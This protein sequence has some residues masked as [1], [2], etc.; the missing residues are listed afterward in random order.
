M[1]GFTWLWLSTLSF[2]IGWITGN[3]SQ[4]WLVL[5]LSDS[6]FWVGLGVGVRGFSQ[7]LFSVPAGALVDRLDRRAILLATQLL[8]VLT[9]TTIGLLV[10]AGKIQLWHVLLYLAVMGM[11]TSAERTATS[12]LLYDMVG[13]SH[14][15]NAS[16]LR[17]MGASAMS[18]PAALAG[19]A[20]VQW[21]GVGFSFLLSAG[22]FAGGA[23]SLLLLPASRRRAAAPERFTR[24]VGQGFRYALRTPP[25]RSLLALSLV[26]E[27]FG[28][29]YLAMMP[30]MARDVLRVGGLGLG[31][32]MATSGAGQL[33]ATAVLVARG[34]VPRKVPMLVVAALG[35]GL[36]IV[37][38]GFSRVLGVSL[39]LVALVHF[40][41]TT[42]DTGLLSALP[43]ATATEM[44]GRVFGLFA[45]T[46][47][48]SQVG[49]LAIGTAATLVGAP[50]AVSANGALTII[51]TLWLLPALRRTALPSGL[52]D[53]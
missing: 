30:V 17:F 47:G 46:L 38:F 21:L 41:G 29:A 53:R 51:G 13:P 2:W 16:A 48:F 9:G 14:M 3:L 6:P 45:A 52:A 5:S 40:F 15:M 43:L 7:A 24:S 12:G 11:L 10:V 19:G 44:R 8:A 22:V 32:L 20:V 49:G 33:L 36:F 4:G 28:Y 35:F 1:P 42:Y 25:V 18:I 27:V 50:L 34:D 23:A 31:Y 26:V 39:A 37:L